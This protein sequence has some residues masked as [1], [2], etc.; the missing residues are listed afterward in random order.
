MMWRIV[1]AIS[2]KKLRWTEQAAR[3][4]RAAYRVLLGKPERRRILGRPTR[5]WKDNIKMDLRE[6]GCGGMDS[7]DLAQ[8]WDR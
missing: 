1:R 8:D 2:S 7:I 4:G 5:T 6:V 3:I